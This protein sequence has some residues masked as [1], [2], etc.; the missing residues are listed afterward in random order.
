MNTY[1]V[2]KQTDVYNF[3]LKEGFS[4]KKIKQLFQYH[5]I[6]VNDKPISNQNHPLKEK[7]QIT[8]LK[9]T[10][11]NSIIDILYE[12]DQILVVNKPAG[13]LTIANKKEKEKTLYHMI[14]NYIK[15]KRKNSKI[16]IIHRLDQDTSGVVMFAKSEKIKQLYQNHWDQLVVKRGYVALVKGMLEK[17]E[18]TLIYYL[19]ENK[20]YQVYVSMTGQKSITKYRVLKETEQYSFVE[21]EL[22]TGRKNQIRAVF[23]HIGHPLVGDKK[24]GEKDDFPRLALHAFQLK[25]KH[26]IHQKMMNFEAKTPSSF[27]S[28]LKK[29]NK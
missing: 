5:S 23:S 22:E 15:T 29:S 7:D 6:K 28:Y 12:D 24:Y 4:K 27:L 21:I 16:F 20:N 14:S 19:K 25:I 8:I 13:L 26:P 18:D 10:K 2:K 3:L 11:I 17:K 1:Y 9:Q